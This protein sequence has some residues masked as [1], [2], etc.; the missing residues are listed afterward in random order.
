MKIIWKIGNLMKS[1]PTGRVWRALVQQ[2]LKRLLPL[3]SFRNVKLPGI[4]WLPASVNMMILHKCRSKIK[5]M[6]EAISKDHISRSNIRKLR[7]I[8]NQFKIVVFC[9][10]NPKLS[11]MKKMWSQFWMSKAL[12]LKGWCQMKRMTYSC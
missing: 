4:R 9:Q 11:K 3:R 7:K 6:V 12:C 8:T 10:F 1:N 5:K 2:L